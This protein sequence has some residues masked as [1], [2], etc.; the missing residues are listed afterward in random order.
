M[1]REKGMVL[2]TSVMFIVILNLLVLTELQMIFVSYQSLNQLKQKH[3]FFFQFELLAKKLIQNNR[4]TGG[5]CTIAE[6]DPNDIVLLL[7]NK[8]G[9]KLN[10]NNYEFNYFIETLGVFPCLQ[11][12]V[13]K[14]RYST[15]HLRYTIRAEGKYQALLQIRIAKLTQLEVCENPVQIPLGVLSWRYNSSI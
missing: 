2:L 12:E 8:K 11:T 15:E 1:I 9:C 6:Q 10:Q 14:R 13:E 3:E 4:A 5:A 7:K